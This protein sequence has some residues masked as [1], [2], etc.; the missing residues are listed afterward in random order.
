MSGSRMR[1]RTEPVMASSDLLPDG[2]YPFIDQAF[3][4]SELA[5]IETPAS[6]KAILVEQ[7]QKN[8]MEIVRDQP[9]EIRCLT[10]QFGDA[11]FLVYWPT[12]EEMHMLAPKQFRHGSA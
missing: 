11:V 6:L 4:L 3:P 10:E 7:A 12:G 9:V 8:G 2:N 5:M 1:F